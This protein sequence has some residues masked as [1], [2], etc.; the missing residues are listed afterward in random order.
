MTVASASELR[1]VSIDIEGMTCSACSSRLERAF[2]KHRGIAEASVNLPLE[3]ATLYLQPAIASIQDV[4]ELVRR[5]G[6][7]VGIV[8]ENYRVEHLRSAQDVAR[9]Q[10]ALTDVPG[11]VGVD[12]DLVTEQVSLEY[13]SRA[14]N[15]D[16]LV[17]VLRN[18]GFQLISLRDL[19]G[20]S[21]DSEESNVDKLKLIISC[22]VCIPFLIQMFAQFLGWEE[23][24]L[25]P[26]G[27]VSLA[28]L[29][30]VLVGPRFYRSAYA[31]IRH[32]SANMDVL[33]SIG[34]T[35]AYLYSWYKMATLGEA[36][37]GTLYFEATAIILT[38]VLIGKRLET[39]AKIISE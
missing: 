29:L 5:T 13:Y 31:A 35:C 30:M 8:E 26:A 36:A 24:H 10:N 22:V 23:I 21:S 9:V 18:V 3:T 32:G 2:S 6:Y 7:D 14:V 27:E 16:R 20:S 39:R 4:V 33:V 1:Q 37:E 19:T 38:L 28:T 11:V 34:T 25:P 15:Q 17:D 12:V